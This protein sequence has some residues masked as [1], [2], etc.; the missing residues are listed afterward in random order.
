[1]LM[2]ISAVKRLFVVICLFSMLFLTIP[3]TT[4]LHA[5]PG[6]VSI[7]FQCEETI[8]IEILGGRVIKFTRRWTTLMCVQGA[9]QCTPQT[10]IPS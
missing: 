9:G 8:E 2:N 1:M 7:P 5:D 3:F 6:Y 4:S 10:C